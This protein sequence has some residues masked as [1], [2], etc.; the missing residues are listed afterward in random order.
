MTLAT[1]GYSEYTIDEINSARNQKPAIYTFVVGFDGDVKGVNKSN[2]NDMAYAGGKAPAN[3][4]NPPAQPCYYSATDEQK[5]KDALAKIIDQTVGGEFGSIMCDDSCYGAGCPPGQVCVKGELS[6]VAQCVPDP[7]MGAKCAKTE[8]CREGKCVKA[9]VDGCKAGEKCK[10]GAC[11][12]DQCSGVTCGAG[13]A[14]NPNTGK[15][16]PDLCAEKTCSGM[17]RCDPGSGRCIDDMCHVIQCPSGT[18]CMQ[19]NCVGK[20]TGSRSGCA[21]GATPRS[22][23]F[24]G[25]LALAFG[26]AVLG[27]VASR[28]R[29]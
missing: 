28:R 13:Q 18:T 26:L 7:C 3:C 19:G 8:F 15:C 29:R 23:D 24:G 20:Y 10:D 14:C 11:V 17:T 27:L 12:K 16:G 5:F 2:L 9:C 4:G 25:A 6:P 22:S 1:S 21:V